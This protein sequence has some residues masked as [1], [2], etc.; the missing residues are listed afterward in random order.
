MIK[1]IVDKGGEGYCESEQANVMTIMMKINMINQ[2]S[3]EGND[4]YY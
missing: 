4:D 2:E 3:Y 1:V